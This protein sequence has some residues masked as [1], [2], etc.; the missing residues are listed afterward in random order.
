MISTFAL[1]LITTFGSTSITS[2]V[3]EAIKG[4]SIEK[5]DAALEKISIET[6][7]SKQQAYLGALLMKKADFLKSPA[8]KLDIFK[9]GHKLL[10]SEIQKNPKNAEY[11]F[12]RLCIQEHAPKILNYNN[13]TEE[14][15]AVIVASFKNLSIDL[16][17]HIKDYSYHSSILVT[18][19]LKD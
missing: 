1:F 8:K 5:V 14:D 4:D 17:G 7:A 3:Y 2:I 9:E 18:K 13:N 11:R 15:K 12:F 6:N 19:E 16:Q 10:E